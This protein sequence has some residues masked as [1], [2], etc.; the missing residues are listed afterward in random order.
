MTRNVLRNFVRAGTLA[1]MVSS[2]ATAQAAD[3]DLTTSVSQPPGLP[4]ITFT[5]ASEEVKL[6]CLPVGTYRTLPVGHSAA[7]YTRHFNDPNGSSVVGAAPAARCTAAQCSA[8]TCRQAGLISGNFVWSDSQ[9]GWLIRNFM[10][11]QV[12]KANG[13]PPVHANG[14]PATELLSLSFP[15]CLKDLNA[16]VFTCANQGL[17]E[18]QIAQQGPCALAPIGDIVDGEYRV[19]A[20]A[21]LNRLASESTA[22]NNSDSMIVRI[23]RGIVSA[24]TPFWQAAESVAGGAPNSGNGPTVLSPLP[25]Q[26]DAFWINN[27]NLIHASKQGGA[28]FG[29]DNRGRPA[30]V[31]LTGQPH[32]TSWAKGRIDIVARGNDSRLWH[33]CWDAS[34]GWC[35]WDN[36]NN[37]SGLVSDPTVDAWGPLRLDIFWIISDGTLHHTFYDH[38]W[39]PVDEGM[40][41]PAATTLTGRPKVVSWGSGNLDIVAM[42]SD[43]KLWD[44]PFHG[45]WGAW[46]SIATN[47]KG[48][49]DIVS[50]APKQLSVVWAAYGTNAIGYAEFDNNTW[51]APKLLPGSQATINNPPAISVLDSGTVQVFARGSDNNLY[52]QDVTIGNGGTLSFWD[53]RVS[54]GVVQSMPAAVSW[55]KHQDTVVYGLSGGTLG[56]V[57]F[58]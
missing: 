16:G 36:P 24:S 41:R 48:F 39:I 11:F 26:I 33:T 23:D 42:G 9:C 14:A 45:S 57:S 49:P 7:N 20:N 40:G 1:V 13:G 32:A 2:A 6:G 44:L 56:S 35:S 17:S 12:L 53:T 46:T 37:V 27:G 21:N 55:A 4:T 25:N 5:S 34:F 47:V 30:N 28:W 38:G 3:P 31:L 54:G 29:G 8:G 51:S 52:S 58:F 15:M 22:R 43:S 19:V 50:V 18:N 10:S